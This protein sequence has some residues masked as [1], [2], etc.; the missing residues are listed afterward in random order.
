MNGVLRLAVLVACLLFPVVMTLSWVGEAKERIV[1]ANEEAEAGPKSGV[2][3]AAAADEQY[4]SPELKRTLRRVVKSCGLLADGQKTSRG[5]QPVD[6]RAV[7]TMSDADFNALFLPMK[8]RGGIVQFEKGKAEVDQAG[9]NLLLKLFAEQRGA[10]YFF[11][12]TRASPE[13]SVKSNRELSEE[14][15][16]ALMTT[17]REATQD[18]DLDREVGLL[19]LGEEYAQ[20]DQSFCNWTR[21][22]TPGECKPEDINRSAFVAWIDCRL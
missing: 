8:E 19:W 20:L 16:Q 17:L 21:S 7:A 4:C 12:V 11:I 9:R 10:S 14:R 22:G 5:C 6:A 13:G 3:I 18:P 1:A 15:A 2:A